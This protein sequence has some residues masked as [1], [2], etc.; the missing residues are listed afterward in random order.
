M[1]KSTHCFDLKSALH[2]LQAIPLHI[3]LELIAV[4]HP[5]ITHLLQLVQQV[6]NEH[7]SGLSEYALIQ[8]LKSRH[9]AFAQVNLSDPLSLFRTHFMLFHVLYLL[10]DRLR[11]AS[12]YDLLIHPLSIRLQP[13]TQAQAQTAAVGHED[14]LRA[15]Y[16]DITQLTSTDRAAVEALLYGG[17]TGLAQPHCVTHALTE[18]DLDQPAH[19]LSAQVIRQQYRVLVS[20]HHPDRGGCTARLQRINQAM[21]T[22]RQ[23][24]LLR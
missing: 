21:D 19:S 1:S 24:R 9:S 4:S 14:T 6:L 10:R 12:Q 20:R 11:H 8:Q 18:L 3:L 2:C 7:P 17:L 15:Y 16:L 22:L 13:A 23:H 5:D